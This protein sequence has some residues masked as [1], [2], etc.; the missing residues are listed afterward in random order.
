MDTNAIAGFEV[1]VFRPPGEQPVQTR[2]LP[3]PGG[4]VAGGMVSSVARLLMGSGN[5]IHEMRSFGDPV[6]IRGFEARLDITGMA[7]DIDGDLLLLDAAGRRLLKIS[8]P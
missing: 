2:R 3:D 1:F 4:F 6:T 7:R 8:E 5:Q